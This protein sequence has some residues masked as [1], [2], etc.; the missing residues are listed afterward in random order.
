ML[1]AMVF[2]DIKA[3]A[4]QHLDVLLRHHL[5]QVLVADTPGRIARTRFF[6]TKN[7][8]VHTYGLEYFHDDG[9]HALVALVE[10]THATHPVQFIGIGIL[11]HQK[12]AQSL[13]PVCPLIVTDFPKVSVALNVVE[14]R[15]HLGRK[16]AL[17]HHQVT[18]HIHN[19]RHVLDRDGAYFHA[20]AAGSTRLERVIRDNAV[21]HRLVV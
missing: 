21:N 9:S 6:A 12:H 7:S 16:I 3:I 1:I 14:E 13:G 8:E 18:A 17:L 20:G 5:P 4:V 11:R 19:L 15:R 10:R 2:S